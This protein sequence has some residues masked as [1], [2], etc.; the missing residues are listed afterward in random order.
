[1]R[2]KK[3]TPVYLTE[4]C[5]QM[6]DENKQKYPDMDDSEYLEMLIHNSGPVADL[7]NPDLRV[8]VSAINVLLSGIFLARNLSRET[9]ENEEAIRTC[10][11]RLNESA[12]NLRRYL[13]LKNVNPYE[14]WEDILSSERR[15]KDK[16]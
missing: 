10:T 9:L 16:C 6:L 4:E 5:Y 14:I 11:N 15:N 8:R 3:R 12:E 1:M 7:V 13:F 2:I